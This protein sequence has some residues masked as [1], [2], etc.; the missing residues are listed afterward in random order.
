MENSEIFKTMKRQ[1]NFLITGSPLDDME[2]SEIF[3]TMKTQWNI[4][5]TG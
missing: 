1:W 3:K 4:M 5:I 2:N